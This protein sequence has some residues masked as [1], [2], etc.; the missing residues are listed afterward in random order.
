MTTSPAS[1]GLGLNMSGGSDSEGIPAT[2]TPGPWDCT[3]CLFP[4]DG[5]GG[6]Y[7]RIQAEGIDA[8]AANARLIATA[9]ELLSALEDILDYTGGADS[10]LDDEYVMGRAAAARA[11]A[12][13]GQ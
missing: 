11:K 8:R 2:F 1:Q 13:G 4:D 5:M 3:G 10:A 12:R 7:Y 6:V 9:P